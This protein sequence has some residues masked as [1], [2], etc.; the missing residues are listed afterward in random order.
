MRISAQKKLVISLL[1]I[2]TF[3][4]PQR[5]SAGELITQ[6]R[7]DR[8]QPSERT[9]GLVCATTPIGNTGIEDTVQIIFP[10]GFSTNSNSSNWT[11]NTTDIPNTASAWPGIST[12]VSVSG[13]TVTFPSGDLDPNTTY[14]FSFASTNTLTT[15]STTGSYE[16]TIRTRNSANS[17]LDS[18]KFGIP[19]VTNDQIRV[20]ATSPAQPTD[21]IVNL[22]MTD[23]SNDYYHSEGRILTYKITYGSNL[24]QASD[25]VVEAE[26]NLGT[27]Q[28]ASVATEDLLDYVVGSA[29][30]GYGGTPPVIDSAN[31]KITWTIPNFPRITNNH[32]VTFKL[33]INSS[34]LTTLPVRFSVDG[35]VY[36]TG[37]QTA[38]STVSSTFQ[39]SAFITP[40]PT[41]TCA[42]GN[43]PTSPPPPPTTPTPTPLPFPKPRIENIEIRTISPTDATLYIATN[44]PARIRVDMGTLISS[45]RTKAFSEQV[46]TQHLMRIDSLKPNTK[47]FFRVF[48]T[49]NN[50]V[51]TTSDLYVLTTASAILPPPQALPRTFILTSED[52]ILS[53]ASASAYVQHIIIPRFTAYSFKVAVKDAKNLKSIKAISRNNNILGITTSEKQLLQ[54]D[55]LSIVEVKPGEFVGKLLSGT[56]GTYKLILQISDFNGNLTEQHIATL[57]IV[58]PIIIENSISKKGIENAKATFS[59]YNPRLRSYS[60]I[61]LSSTPIK[62][63]N[64]SQPDGTITTVLPQGKYRVT[65]EALGYESSMQ[66]FSL[67]PTSNSFYPLIELTPQ[68]FNPAIYFQY[69]AQAA[70]D[71][72]NS[73]KSFMQELRS[74][75]RFFDLL[76]FLMISFFVFLL[77][78]ATSK[79]LSIPIVLLPYFVLYEL[80]KLFIKRTHNFIFHGRILTTGAGE[81]VDGARIYISSRK[82]K[83]ITQAKTN[84][85]GEFFAKIYEPKNIR[86]TISKK[87]FENYSTTVSKQQL[88]KRMTLTISQIGKPKAFSINTIK[89]Y[90]EYILS[91]LLETVLF[92]AFIIQILFVLEFGWLTALPFLLISL[93]NFILWVIHIKPGRV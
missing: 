84:M 16:G 88:E 83:I 29:S 5:M 15:P 69:I 42:P 85:Y 82:G 53:D 50:G 30:Y 48:A 86:I 61:S 52:V 79:R 92:I 47:Y 70:T 60:D 55:S 27:I 40:T 14:C 56:N 37:T 12:A 68:P 17:L 11:V 63:P 73:C 78:I 57:Y 24:S 75:Y 58:N 89:W 67:D 21:Y 36:G 10:Q 87:G 77:T 90:I 32:T 51:T 72:I 80:E 28:G 34:S 23:P 44:I 20:T 6:I 31:R 9:G 8:H 26:W 76:S 49:T 64:Y 66:E 59:L 2:V 62:N 41:P 7:I 4:L 91:S 65:V 74:S 93:I 43:C 1:L 3:L 25:I 71:V 22:E 18:K 81:A 33:Q 45:L 39:R 13:T 46:A 38:D 19:I 35:R 54:T